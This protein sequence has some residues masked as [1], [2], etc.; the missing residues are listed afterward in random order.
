MATIETLTL[1]EC[2]RSDR[3]NELQLRPA[4]AV[5]PDDRV[6]DVVRCM[7][8][9]RTGCALVIDVGAGAAA[10]SAAVPGDTNGNGR[11]HATGG[12]AGRL[13]GIFTERDFLARIVATGASP[14][15]PVRD[16][17][18]SDPVTVNEH[19]SVGRAVELMER[20]GYRHLPV[21]GP[22]PSGPLG[23]VSVKDVVH[24]LV[25]YFPSNVYNLPP[26]PDQTQPAREGA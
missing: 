6:R 2:L 19:D 8:E 12:P 11:G 25:E 5:S 3:V 7:T 15:V 4:C 13:I 24:Y 18:T 23:V 21:M 1:A 14:D 10:A 26:T 16:V 17:M 22:A 9:R 20:G